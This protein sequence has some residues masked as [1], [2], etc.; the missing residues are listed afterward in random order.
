MS[1]T[2]TFDR[3]VR[4]G[5][6]PSLLSLLAA[7]DSSTAPT[8]RF[9]RSPAEAQF[10]TSDVDRFWTARALGGTAYQA[11]Y[12][13]SGTAALREFAASRSVTAASLQQMSNLLPQYLGAVRQWWSGI[14]PADPMFAI[15]RGNYARL[16]AL[17][18]DATFPP[19]YFVVGRFST[20][21]TVNQHGLIIGTEF[22]GIDAQAPTGELSAFAGN[23]Q[24]SWRAD[25][26]LLVAHE[27]AHHLQLAAGS[28]SAAAGQTL[29]TRALN[30][31]GAEF[32][33]S[34]AAG[35][36]SFVKFFAAWQA[37]EREFFLAFAAERHGTGIKRWL[38]NQGSI[39]DNAN[40]PWPGDLG[41]FMGFRIAQAYYAKATDKTQAL[42]D[43]LLVRDAE[44]IFQAS[45]YA[46]SGPPIVVP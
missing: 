33:G 5:V 15:M 6:L 3:A 46:G 42:R 39:A 19:V 41:Y 30:E 16:G 27:H 37:R 11:R 36:P 29:L 9:P 43:L 35:A 23:N 44:A 4:R 28:R 22:Y 1:R 13:D 38:F 10:V 34:L 7:C 31:G 32:V 45:G 40:A 8:A 14:G 24:K 21:G 18:P 25:L 17:L 20:G 2:L 12:L 26:P